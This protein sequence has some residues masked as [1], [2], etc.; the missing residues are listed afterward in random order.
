VQCTG[1]WLQYLQCLDKLQEFATP[2][3][4]KEFILVYVHKQFSPYSPAM[5]WS[6]SF[7]FLSVGTLKTSYVF[8][9]NWKWRAISP[10]NYGRL[11]TI[12]HWH[13]TSEIVPG[14][15]DQT[16]SSAQWFMWRTFS[17]SVVYC[18]LTT[19]KNS[20]GTKLGTHIANIVCQM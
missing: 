16:C 7:G 5:C 4:G 17:A 15:H 13:R 8:S 2:T 20:T 14:V 6:Q 18:D 3:Q 12:H 10:V 11:Q 9:S 19:S 1:M